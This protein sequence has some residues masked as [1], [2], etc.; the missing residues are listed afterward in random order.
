MA[1]AVKPCNKNPKMANNILLFI[2]L[3]LNFDR[4]EVLSFLMKELTVLKL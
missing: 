3:N 4:F 2:N 1:I